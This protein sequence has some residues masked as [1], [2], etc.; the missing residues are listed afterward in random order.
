[1][2]IHL[3]DVV[4]VDKQRVLRRGVVRVVGR[5]DV[6]HELLPQ[7]LAARGAAVADRRAKN[8][9]A[10]SLEGLFVCVTFSCCRD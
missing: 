8:P 3:L 1:M 7:N 10:D 4:Q 9:G 6:A 2:A 5:D